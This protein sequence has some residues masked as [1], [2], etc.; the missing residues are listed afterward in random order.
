MAWTERQRRML[1]EIGIRVW[2]P[3]QVD[4]P[5]GAAREPGVSV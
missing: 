5:V 1:E 3:A 2:M 4:L